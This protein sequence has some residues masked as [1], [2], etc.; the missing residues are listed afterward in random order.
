MYGLVNK[1]DYSQKQPTI[2]DDFHGW[3]DDG[4]TIFVHPIFKALILKML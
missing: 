4:A 2:L 1:A 3:A